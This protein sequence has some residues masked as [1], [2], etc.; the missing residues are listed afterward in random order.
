MLYKFEDEG[1]ACFVT[2]LVIVRVREL[3]NCALVA[4]GRDVEDLF[5][6]VLLGERDVRKLRCLR[7]RRRGWARA[8]RRARSRSARRHRPR[9]SSSAQRA[10]V[11]QRPHQ[12]TERLRVGDD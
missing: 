7:A 6:L 5:R 9:A 10:A 2:R 3:V 4:A 1:G 11:K 8:H 12:E